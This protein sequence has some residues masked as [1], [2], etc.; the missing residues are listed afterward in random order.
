MK[1][2][3]TLSTYA[4]LLWSLATT[5]VAGAA[6][7]VARYDGTNNDQGVAI[8]VDSTG[9]TYVTGST[10]RA[11]TNND[12]LTIKY[13]PNGA[14]LW[15]QVYNGSGYVDDYPATIKLDSAGNVVVFGLANRGAGNGADYVTLKYDS[16]GVMQ[17]VRAFNGSASLNEGPVAMA[18]DSSN[19]IFVTGST[20]PG[21]ANTD[22]LTVAYN[23][24]GALLWARTYGGAAG[25]EDYPCGIGVDN[26][27][28][29]YVAGSA[30]RDAGFGKDFVTIKY[31]STGTALWMRA[32]SGSAGGDDFAQGISVRGST[33]DVFVTG[34]ALRIGTGNDYVTL[35]YDTSG[36]LQW[37]QAYNGIGNGTDIPHAITSDNAGNVYVTGESFGGAGQLKDYATIKYNSSGVS[38]WTKRT[39]SALDDIAA[40]IA[41]DSSYNVYVTGYSTSTAGN[42]KDYYTAKYN[43]GGTALF[44]RRF[45][46]SAL[47]EDYASALAIDSSGNIYVT[48][49][50]TNNGGNYDIITIKYVP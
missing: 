42:N 3:R 5:A 12:I 35:R 23:S 13:D 46:S 32:Y 11:G 15:A 29:V 14:L 34:S 26:S 39:R 7:W 6:P 44:D 33:G 10:S 22:F 36:A 30:V 49:S 17:W 38:Q 31:D 16:N 24:A 4:L 19:N 1:S 40:S 50:S 25:G 45:N 2:L 21:G 8:A 48:G 43:S 9:N 37:A 47:E 20:D 27:G 18:I 41:V 28:N